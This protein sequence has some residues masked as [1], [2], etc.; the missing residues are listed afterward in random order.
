M[1]DQHRDLVYVFQ[2]KINQV[3]GFK[4]HKF[5]TKSSKGHKEIKMSAYNKGH[6]SDIIRGSY[7][8][9]NSLS[10]TR[11]NDPSSSAQNNSNSSINSPEERA[12]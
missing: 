7:F 12:L 9:I 5:E 6:T 11:V 10:P 2:A 3:S 8:D 4:L 1:Y